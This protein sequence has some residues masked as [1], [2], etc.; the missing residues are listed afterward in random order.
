[1]GAENDKSPFNVAAAIRH[2]ISLAAAAVIAITLI[3]KAF[4]EMNIFPQL[5]GDQA[6]ALLNRTL[7]YIF[8]FAVVVLI[9]VIVTIYLK[10]SDGETDQQTGATPQSVVPEPS[11]DQ[12]ESTAPPEES[13]PPLQ[14]PPPIRPTPAGDVDTG[15]GAY[16]GGDVDTEGGEFIGR[17]QINE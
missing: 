1:M 7:T 2:P 10:D 15:G 11:A 12:P 8:I 4:L 13:I 3:F 17:D 14:D 16:I 6:F 5:S 9:A